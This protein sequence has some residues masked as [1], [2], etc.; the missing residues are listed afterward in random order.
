MLH[1]LEIIGISLL[2]ISLSQISEYWNFHDRQTAH[3]A[4]VLGCNGPLCGTQQIYWNFNDL[5]ASDLYSFII[6]K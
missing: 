3:C 6:H 2:F 1:H 4:P 5:V